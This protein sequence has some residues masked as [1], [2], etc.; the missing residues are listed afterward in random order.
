MP[1]CHSLIKLADVTHND[2]IMSFVNDDII[3]NV[4]R[5]EIKPCSDSS[6]DIFVNLCYDAYI[7]FADQVICSLYRSFSYSCVNN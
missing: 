4:I 5:L 2:R 1:F 6:K 7:S 3:P